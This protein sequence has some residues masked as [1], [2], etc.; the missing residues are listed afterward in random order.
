MQAM[1]CTLADL[2]SGGC[3]VVLEIKPSGPFRSR[4]LDMG[5]TAGQLIKVRRKAPLGGPMSIEL[6][7]YLLALRLADARTI[8]VR[9]HTE[10]PAGSNRVSPS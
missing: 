9:P 7:G 1:T 8:I 5:L 10:V 4:L 3:G 6:R 2:P